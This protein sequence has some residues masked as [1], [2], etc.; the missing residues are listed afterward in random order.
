MGVYFRNMMVN[1]KKAFI[2]SA[3]CCIDLNFRSVGNNC[4]PKIKKIKEMINMY[5]KLKERLAL[6][7]VTQRE[8]SFL[9]P[10]RWIARLRIF[11]LFAFFYI[12]IHTY[13]YLYSI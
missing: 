13:I 1:G 10:K 12:Y 5:W 9:L 4:D 2:H 6:G 7:K 11:V 3:L 8:V